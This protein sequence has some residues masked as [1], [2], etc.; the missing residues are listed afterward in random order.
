MGGYIEALEQAAILFPILAV[1]FTIP[2]I[3]WNY[4]KYGSVLSLRILI[5]YSFILYMLCAYCLVI[6]PLP[7]GEAAANLS[8]H[9]AQ[10]V[11]FTFLGDIARESDAVLSQPRT[12]LT[13]FNSNAFLTTLFNL[14][15]TMPF[16][17]YLRYYFRCGWKRTLVYSLLLSL[18]FELTQ[19]SGLYFIYSGSYRLF[20]VDDLI[21]NTCGSMIG[22][23]LAR[24][25]MRFLP[26]REELDRESFVRGR[27]VSLLRRIVAFIYDEIA[28][29]VLFIVVFLIWTANFGT[30]SVWVYAL[31]WLAYF[32][33][34][35]I[36]L[37][38]QTIGHRL[39]KLRIVSSG[40][41]RAH[42]YQYALR[43]TLLFVLLIIA[44]VA[45]NWSISFLAGRGLLGEP[46]SVL[47]YG[48]VDGG[49]LFFLLFEAARMAMRRQLFYERW[50]KTKLIS[51]VEQS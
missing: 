8:G 35:P 16:G 23:V 51:T 34:C 32:A 24:I 46:A 18:F 19:L 25:A 27:R 4:H 21:V 50:S 43:Y 7:T 15:L 47:A 41:G 49:Y 36:V 13:V 12:W 48:I 22:F 37:R 26:S 40:G 30:M 11:P 42:W 6:L 1:L 44:P 2:Y 33:L 20:D 3:A 17:M 5:V 31:I 14:F 28:Y 29:A 10:L 9:Q 39:T 38:G 45:L